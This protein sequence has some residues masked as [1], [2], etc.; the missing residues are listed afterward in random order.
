MLLALGWLHRLNGDRRLLSLADQVIAFIDGHL[1]DRD[2]GGL[3]DQFPVTDR[4]KRQNP[5]MHLLE[6]YLALEEAAPGRGYLDRACALVR[7]FN[8]RLFNAELGVLSE[9]FSERWGHHPDPLKRQMIQVERLRFPGNVPTAET[10]KVLYA[11]GGDAIKKAAALFIAGGL[12]MIVAFMRDAIGADLRRMLESAGVA[13][14]RPAAGRAAVPIAATEA[15][16]AAHPGL[17]GREGR[18]NRESGRRRHDKSSHF[19]ISFTFGSRL[20]DFGLRLRIAGRREFY[21]RG[22]V[23]FLGSERARRDRWF[24]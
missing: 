9:H 1:S 13:A 19:M 11:E 14:M 22:L 17:R 16:A 24:R 4:R 20:L 3:F 8:E 10:L 5:Q 7:L 6:A 2:H 15:A 21:P 23:G 18:T 12:G